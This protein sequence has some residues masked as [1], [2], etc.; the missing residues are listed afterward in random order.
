MSEPTLIVHGGARGRALAVSGSR[1]VATG[2]DDEILSLRGGAT[3]LLDAAGGTIMP[4]FHDAHIHPVIGM[5]T[6]MRCDLAADTDVPGYLRRID[7]YRRAETGNGWLLGGGWL[8]EV[9]RTDPR[10]PRDIL[11]SV[12]GKRPAFLVEGGQHDAWVNSAALESAG[13]G[14]DTPD[15]PLG[16]IWR[17][18]DGVPTG[19]LSETAMNLIRDTLPPPTRRE[20]RDALAAAQRRLFSAGIVRWHDAVVGYTDATMPLLQAYLDAAH[21]GTLKTHVALA[22]RWDRAR[23]IEQVEELAAARAEH[24][25]HP[26]VRVGTV[27]IFQDGV[28]ESRTAALSE[29]YLDPHGEGG[30]GI[31]MLGT[32]ELSEAV[33]RLDS[34]GFQVHVHAIGDRAIR[35]ALDA[36]ESARATNGARDARHQI[37][38]VHLLDPADIPRFARLGVIANVQPRWAHRDA[39]G[40]DPAEALVGRERAGWQYPFRAL[41]ESGAAV[42]FG[43]DWP[44]TSFDPIEILH[45][46]MNRTEP[47]ST[48]AP[49]GLQQR[50]RRDRALH[51][52]TVG[53]A[54]ANFAETDTSQLGA[55]FSADLVVL[56]QD[57]STVP[58]HRFSDISIHATVAAGH[59]V[60]TTEET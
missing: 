34:L 39:A 46:A 14:R 17:N 60:H 4:A 45:L 15:P 32:A 21:E 29:P 27:K 42:A 28:C 22:L 56:D 8:A 5:L 13:I 24:A 43:S 18:A 48:V 7:S 1:I 44:V 25:A 36:F 23:G 9:L 53:S 47:G 2:S 50:L 11:D 26:R 33:T 59:I 10:S 37:S 19:L 52:F 12:T 57:I 6:E 49:L 16:R 40:V 35:D 3:Q 55:G 30:R 41:D 54:V 20:L 38:H 31:S 51:A 58:D